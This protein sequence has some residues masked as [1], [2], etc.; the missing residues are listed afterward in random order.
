MLHAVDI[1]F[2][3]LMCVSRLDGGTT[4]ASGILTINGGTGAK[5]SVVYDIIVAS[6]IT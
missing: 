1:R 4:D 2:I 5:G 3:V 6:G